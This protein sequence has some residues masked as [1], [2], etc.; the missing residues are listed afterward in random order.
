MTKK[1]KNIIQTKIFL[2]DIQT[3]YKD[4]KDLPKIEGEVNQWCMDNDI[5]N[6]E[7]TVLNWEIGDGYIIATL[8]YT[9][10]KLVPP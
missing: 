3:K 9:K 7:D 4:L 5:I 6:N 1:R 8:C 10:V 2:F